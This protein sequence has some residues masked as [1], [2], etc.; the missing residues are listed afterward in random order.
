MLLSLLSTRVLRAQRCIVARRGVKIPA[1]QLH[2]KCVVE[3]DDRL[4]S[5]VST[6]LVTQGR[7]GS[8]ITT[9]LR[10]VKDNKVKL[11]RYNPDDKL[12]R[13]HLGDP[14]SYSM[15]YRE[16]DMLML[17]HDETFEQIEVL[18][19]AIDEIPRKFLFDGV[20]LE[21]RSFRGE[22]L[23]VE[24]PKEVEMVV[25]QEVKVYG[26]EGPVTKVVALENGIEVKVPGFVDVGEI[27]V[28]KTAD[29]SYSRRLK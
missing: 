4:W 12:E 25:S 18:E 16:G 27:I 5:V 1:N 19:T 13:V 8:H 29:A 21:V 7:G 17:M 20:K 14:E 26:G 9:E 28:V 22:P 23:N 3:I 24:L 6:K 11:Q 2:P 10:D 15:L